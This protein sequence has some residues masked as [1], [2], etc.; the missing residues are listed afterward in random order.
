VETKEKS[1]RYGCPRIA[2]LVGNVLGEAIDEETVRRI[3][4]KHYRPIPGKEPSWPLPIGNSYN[5]LWS[6]DLFRLESVF[7]RSFWV[8]VVMNQFT[9]KIIGFSVH[10][11]D[12]NGGA[13]CFMFNKIA[14]GKI[15]PKYLSTDNDPLFKYWLWK[16]NLENIFYIEEI[17]TVPSCPWSHPFV[18]RLISSCRREFTDH[19]F[20]WSE[21]DL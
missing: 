5:K 1:P 15:W 12:L 9:R 13:I 21:G 8:M 4:A 7:L 11:G 20:F 3:L 18:E 19:V 2:L 16:A 14:A 17:K 10:R 6:M